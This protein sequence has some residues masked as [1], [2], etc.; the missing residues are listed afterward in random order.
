M[1]KF[2]LPL[3]FAVVC[4][5]PNGSTPYPNEYYGKGD[6]FEPEKKLEEVT[7]AKGNRRI[8]KRIAELKKLLRK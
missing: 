4:R 3:L 5:L 2:A 1:F 7:S 6:D 8:E